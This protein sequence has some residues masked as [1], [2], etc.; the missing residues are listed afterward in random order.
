MQSVTHIFT[1]GRPGLWL[2]AVVCACAAVQALAQQQ[3]LPKPPE[4]QVPMEQ[5]G[6][7][8]EERVGHPLPLELQFTDSHGK[9]VTLKDYF[10]GSAAG[11]GDGDHRPAVVVLG[12]YRCPVV[13]GLIREKLMQTLDKVDY[14]LGKDY[15][16]LIFSFDPGETPK[17]AESVRK[18]DLSYYARGAE[19]QP[20]AGPVDSGVA[21]HVS[22]ASNIRH[23]AD[24]LGY[25]YKL[26]GNNEY[27]HPVVV[28]L[29]A[30]DGTISRYLYGFSQEPATMKMAIM[31]ASEGKLVRTVGERLMAFCYMYDPKKG[32]YTLQ[33]F[34]VMQ[35]GAVLTLVA[36]G[37]LL[38]VLFAGERLRKKRRLAAEV[39]GA[40]AG[41]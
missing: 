30:P 5:R 39:K 3:E 4:P 7:D 20:D 22:D 18:F 16:V 23:L 14:T 2:A 27:S 28:V 34:R 12:Y 1:T 21:Y 13:C 10:Q 6:V 26:L 37:T 24:A 11:A 35:V 33:A 36:L 38:A 31:E 40:V 15:R 32:A 8:V 9:P 17:A 29:V 25:R 41:A 19:G